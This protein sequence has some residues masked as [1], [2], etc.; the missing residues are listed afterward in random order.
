MLLPFQKW[1]VN[2]GSD[3][4]IHLFWSL[5]LSVLLS[6]VKPFWYSKLNPLWAFI[7]VNIRFRSIFGSIWHQSTLS[8]GKETR[9][10]S[11][12][13]ILGLNSSIFWGFFFV[14]WGIIYKIEPQTE[15]PE[16]KIL[17]LS[18]SFSPHKFIFSS[19]KHFHLR[20]AGHRDTIL[21][22]A[23]SLQCIIWLH[24]SGLHWWIR[25]RKVYQRLQSYKNGQSRQKQNCV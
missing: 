15:S 24:K 17:V 9:A 16:W 22:Q 23:N 12:R 2:K 11:F 18:N 8:K 1:N 13:E 19:L 25:I 5:E 3:N 7:Q 6:Y 4:K 10:R 20:K 21:K 14:N